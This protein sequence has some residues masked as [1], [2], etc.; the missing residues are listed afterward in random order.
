MPLHLY[1]VSHRDRCLADV[2][3]AAAAAKN[4]ER[5]LAANPTVLGVV[6]L[7]TCNRVEIYLD[8]SHTVTASE[9]DSSLVSWAHTTGEEALTH[10]FTVAAGL[11]SMVMGERE[12]IG[13]VRRAFVRAQELDNVTP[14]LGQCFGA[15]LS[16]SRKVAQLAGLESMGRS[17]VAVALDMAEE[18]QPLRGARVLL[19]GT[20]SYAGATV[21]ALRSRG[22]EEIVSY[23]TSDR[24]PAFAARHQL[25]SVDTEGLS[26]VMCAADFVVTCRGH[27]PIFTVD[28]ISSCLL[29]RGRGVTIVDLALTRDVEL[30]VGNLDGVKLI[31]LEK[32]R[33]AVPDL[34]RDQLMLATSVVNEGVEDLMARLRAREADPMV[35]QLRERLARAVADEASRLPSDGMISVDVARRALERLANRIAHTPTVNAQAAARQ[36]NADEWA[37][38]LAAVFSITPQPVGAGIRKESE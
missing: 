13:Q 22:V 3:E 34:E 7:S 25:V 8:L 11:D 21:A 33:A 36:G 26:E 29:K 4:L 30:E 31:D 16:T 38:A 20:G 37:R 17:V 2:A 28:D 5:K 35:L 1:S 27:Q 32:V 6:M 12:I 14:F 15:A 10:L 9:L 19:V 18:T 23:S 24:G